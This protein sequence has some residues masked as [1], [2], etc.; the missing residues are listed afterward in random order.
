MTIELVKDAYRRLKNHIYY[1][2]TSLHLRKDIC[3]FEASYKSFERDL[4]DLAEALEEPD[5]NSSY[6][7]KLIGQISY[8]L[9]AKEFGKARNIDLSVIH[10]QFRNKSYTV[11][12]YAVFAEIPIQLHIVATLFIKLFGCQIEST[13]F[14][15]PY[16]NKLDDFE[17]LDGTSLKEGLKLYKPYPNEYKRWRN[18]AINCIKALDEKGKNSVLVSLDVKDFYFSSRVDFEFLKSQLLLDRNNP[19]E[20]RV[21]KIVYEI[22]RAYA[23]KINATNIEDGLPLPIGLMTSGVLANWYLDSLDRA[24]KKKIN[25]EYYG[26]Y[27]DDILIVL[28]IKNGQAIPSKE[29]YLEMVFTKK[30]IFDNQGGEYNFLVKGIENLQVQSGKLQVIHFV[31]DELTS[32][33]DKYINDSK[34]DSSEYRL[35]ADEDS[36]DAD[37]DEHAFNLEYT[38]SGGGLSDI[39]GFSDDKFGI[40]YYLGKKLDLALQ[41]A[42]RDEG[43]SNKKLLRLFNGPMAIDM[44]RLWEKLFTYFLVSGELKLFHQLI[45]QIVQ[46]MDKLKSNDGSLEFA[47]LERFYIYHLFI[48]T[49]MA[50]SLKPSLINETEK[51][52][53]NKIFMRYPGYEKFFDFVDGIRQSNMVRHKYIQ[54]PLLN[55]LTSEKNNHI[56]LIHHDP[57]YSTV[58]QPLSLCRH[59]LEYS[60]RFVN[61]D[62]VMSFEI[63]I[64][65]LRLKGSVFDNSKDLLSS[66]FKKYYKI[67]YFDNSNF[68]EKEIRGKLFTSRP[69]KKPTPFVKEITVTPSESLKK[70]TVGLVNMEVPDEVISQKYLRKPIIT[71]DRKTYLNRILDEALKVSADVLVFPEISIPVSRLFWLA[72]YARKNQQAMIF[73]LEHW[74]INKHA[75]NFIV[76]FLPIKVDGY[77]SLVMNIRLKNHYSP[78]EVDLLTGYG[79][80]IP[81]NKR[82]KY[83]LIHW[84]NVS[85]T[86]F[87]CFE[88]CNIEHRSYFRSRIDVLFASEFNRDVPYFSNI[89]ES[90]TRDLHCYIAQSNDSKYGDSRLTQPKKSIHRDIVNIKGGIFPTIIVGEL[91]IEGLRDFQ[92][93]DYN[94]QNKSGIFKPTP[95]DFDKMNVM[96]RIEADV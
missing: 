93:L 18:N 4:N 37:F 39:K 30:E 74:V 51:N 31:S 19:L 96:E 46:T 43:S 38:K 7:E 92:V 50:Y 60:S 67:N 25:V 24:I 13:L 84:R 86:A 48:S 45:V 64:S 35:I 82:I 79:Y 58:K 14:T 49:G 95:P 27:V 9:A 94:G 78:E 20:V 66:A 75:M 65:I 10:S 88:L 76:E 61:F 69:V 40:S 32:M 80:K 47:K 57:Y 63:L 6:W 81:E 28:P 62:E 33:L 8:S 71:S 54:C 2:S 26:R 52:K 77:R 41:G 44:Y 87:N 90:A 73:G 68:D 11:E 72:D 91:D 3:M 53:L 83:D 56:D 59:K 89:V 42:L 21:F 36:I 5:Y 70:L 55:Y 85:F 1:D 16:G 15:T 23:K 34:R 22:H 29:K 17:H 12:R